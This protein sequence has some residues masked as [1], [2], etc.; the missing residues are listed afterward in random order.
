[1]KIDVKVNMSLVFSI[2]IYYSFQQYIKHIVYYHQMAFVPG[3]KGDLTFEN[4]PMYFS[5][6]KTKWEQ[7]YDHL[8]SWGEGQA[9]GNI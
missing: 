1:M 4:Q 9:F 7:P 2:L 8:N 6:L 5:I 3:Y